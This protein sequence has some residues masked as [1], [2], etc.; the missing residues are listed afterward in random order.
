[1]KIVPNFIMHVNKDFLIRK[2][3]CLLGLNLQLLEDF[4]LII[5]KNGKHSKH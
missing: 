4:S 1:M 5:L 2:Y 3:W